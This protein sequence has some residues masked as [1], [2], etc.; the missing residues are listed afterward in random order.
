MNTVTSTEPTF[1]Y[2]NKTDQGLTVFFSGHDPISVAKQNALYSDLEAKLRYGKTDGL[3]MLANLAA[4]V[5]AHSKGKFTLVDKDG[6]DVVLLYN[7]PMPAALSEFTLQFVE[8]GFNTDFIERFWK[9]LCQNPSEE[10]RESLYAFLEA[11]NMTLTDDGCFIGYRAISSDWKDLRTGTMDNSIGSSPSMPRDEVDPNPEN[12]CS[13]GLHIAAW[14]F[15]KGFGY[16]DYR[17]V[18]VKVNPKDVVTVPPDYNNQ[19][20]RVCKFTVLNEVAEKRD[21]L[22]HPDTFADPSEWD[23]I[24]LVDDDIVE[25]EN[26]TSLVDSF[27]EVEE[28]DSEMFELNVTTLGGVNIP[29]ELAIKAGFSVGDSAYIC[30]DDVRG[31][32]K[33]YKTCCGVNDACS[34]LTVDKHNSIRIGSSA[35]KDW[36]LQSGDTVEAYFIETGTGNY[37]E[38]L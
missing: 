13:R 35:F 15:A 22:V 3:Y 34:I 29:K 2:A 28:V 4:R 8:Q 27:D 14:D 6:Q 23:D 37:I 30:R 38:I 21:S 19:K 33:I 24:S 32:V 36:G 16:S 18:E 5:K 20:M 26:D 11:N 1:I 7:K 31:N 17:L 9:N 25:E 12:T 10:S